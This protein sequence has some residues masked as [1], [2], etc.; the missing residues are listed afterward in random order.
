MFSL[1][2]YDAHMDEEINRIA[3]AFAA[4][5]KAIEELKKL[6]VFRS[7]KGVPDFSEWLVAQIYRGRLATSKTQ[8]GWDVQTDQGKI[9][10]K[11]HFK[12]DD[13]ANRWSYVSVRHPFD[14]LVL[15]VLS[16]SFKVLEFY[17]APK[18]ALIL[19]PDKQ[20]TRLN[21]SDLKRWRIPN[22]QITDYERLSALFDDNEA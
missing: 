22:K 17:K 14:S 15:I 3:T 11:V 5:A 16:D 2:L 13:P 12:P 1:R 4:M 7:R 9:Q 19:K 21:W 20:G 18:D 8:K 10:V 6:G